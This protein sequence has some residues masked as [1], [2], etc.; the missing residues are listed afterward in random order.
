MEERRNI[1][2]AVAEAQNAPVKFDPK[3]RAKY[4]RDTVK[5]IEEYQ[6]DRLTVEEIKVRVPTF[7]RDYKNLFEELTAPGGYNKQSLT[8][9]LAMLDRMGS[10]DLTQHQASVI[11]GQRLAQTYD[12]TPEKL[13]PPSSSQ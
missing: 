4:I 7:A 8:T 10:G 11:V 12:I 1:R 5:Q 6:R 13:P 3:S 9:M 2:E